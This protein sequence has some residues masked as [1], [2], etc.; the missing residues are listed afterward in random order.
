[1]ITGKRGVFDIIY[2]LIILFGIALIGLLVYKLS[3][4]ITGE[5][6][7]MQEINDTP[8]AREANLNIRN[9]APYVT[10]YFVFFFFLGMVIAL[11]VAAVRT[12]FSPVVVGLFI[13]L[14]IITILISSGLVNLYR[15]F[16]DSDDLSDVASR[17][18][19]TNIIFS[20]YTPLIITILSAMI[21]AVMW[22]KSGS[23][24][25]T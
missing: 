23:R 16:A 7:Q 6:A 11:M 20:R 8:Y 13:L 10:D 14:L 21:L 12:D 17:L 24:I 2:L 1:M 9:I 3:D 22:G 18:T 19:F 15:G 4:G 25:P 5:Y